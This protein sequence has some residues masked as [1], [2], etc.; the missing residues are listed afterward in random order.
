MVFY[1]AKFFTKCHNFTWNFEAIEPYKMVLKEWCS[2]KFWYRNFDILYMLSGAGNRTFTRKTVQR[3]TIKRKG[4]MLIAI[5][6]NCIMKENCIVS[7]NSAYF[8]PY[9][10]VYCLH[11]ILNSEKNVWLWLDL[12][13]LS[14]PPLLHLHFFLSS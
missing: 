6:A 11:C 14:S 7:C 5:F 12:S 4:I 2:K 3:I 9:Y 1:A 10:Y 8:V 13:P